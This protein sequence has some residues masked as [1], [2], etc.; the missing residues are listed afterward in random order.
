MHTLFRLLSISFFLSLSS[1]DLFSIL[2]NFLGNKT[3]WN[4]PSGGIKLM[5]RSESNL[6]SRTHW[7]KVQ[8]SMAIDCFPLQAGIEGI[9]GTR[10]WQQWV[11]LG[12][13]PTHKGCNSLDKAC[14]VIYGKLPECSFLTLG[15]PFLELRMSGSFANSLSFESSAVWTQKFQA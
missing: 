13:P 5:L 1:H 10:G 7:W 15:V 3:Q 12:D 4:S 11:G 2:S 9:V 8:S 14:T 6:L